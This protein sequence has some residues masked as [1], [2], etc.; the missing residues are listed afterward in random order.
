MAS[1]RAGVLVAHAHHE[2]TEGYQRS[3]RKAKFFSAKETGN[4]DI[5]TG[6]ELTIGLNDDAG[7]QVVEE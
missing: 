2:A 4:G 3:S 7:T 1:D 6:L 5:A